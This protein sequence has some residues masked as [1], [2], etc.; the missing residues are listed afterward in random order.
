[1]RILREDLSNY[2]KFMISTYRKMT[3]ISFLLKKKLSPIILRFVQRFILDF[4]Q[5]K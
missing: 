1:M 2:S 4:G 3:K 5:N